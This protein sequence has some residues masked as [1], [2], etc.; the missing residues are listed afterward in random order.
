LR[1]RVERLGERFDW[2]ALISHYNDAHA[3][4]LER[5][6]VPARPGRVDVRML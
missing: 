3:V 1:N 2:S 5:G 4:A 6:G